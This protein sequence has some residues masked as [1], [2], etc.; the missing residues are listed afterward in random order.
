M[1]GCEL[2]FF[3]FYGWYLAAPGSFMVFIGSWQKWCTEHGDWMNANG[4][5]GWFSRMVLDSKQW[6]LV[7]LVVVLHFTANE[8]D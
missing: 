4:S 2:V 1:R 7:K 3:V 5:A 8:F 6:Y